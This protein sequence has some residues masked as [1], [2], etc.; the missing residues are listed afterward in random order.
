MER[1]KKSGGLEMRVFSG[2]AFIG[3]LLERSMP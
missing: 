2:E 1:E 3:A